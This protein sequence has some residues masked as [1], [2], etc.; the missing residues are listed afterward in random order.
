MQQMLA[1]I[2]ADEPC[3]LTVMQVILDEELQNFRF[4]IRRDLGT[5]A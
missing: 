2:A 5:D 4:Y 1:C 3:D